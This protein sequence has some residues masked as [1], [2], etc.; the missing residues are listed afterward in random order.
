MSRDPISTRRRVAP[1][2]AFVGVL[3]TATALLGACTEGDDDTAPTSLATTTST[4]VTRDDDGQLVLGIFLPRTGAGAGLGQP[5]IAAID[6]A[7]AE[8][9]QVGGVL[10]RPV[11]RELV[12]E[13]SGTGMAELVQLGVDAII[14]P[15]SST[16]ALAQLD[17]AVQ[18][19]IGVV[20]C[21][22]SAT[23]LALDDYP[24]NKFFFRTV[25]SDSL[26]MT[27]I[28][29]LAAGTGV[30]S[31][32][33][34]YVDDVYGRGLAQAFADDAQNRTFTISAEVPF[35]ADQEELAATA[36]QLL[37][38]APGVVVVLGGPDDGTRLLAALDTATQGRERPEVIVNDAVRSGR[39]A[40]P[41]LSDEFREAIT[42]VAPLAKPVTGEA[43]G[44]F[45]ANAVDCVNLIALAAEQARS[46]S[47]RFI[48][49]QMAA[50]SVGGA[51]CVSFA[52]CLEKINDN[53]LIDYNGQTGSVELSTTTG[54]LVR[55]WF[56]AFA[57]DAEG[58]D[59]K[60][61]PGSPFQ[62]P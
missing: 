4:V 30:D 61:E 57:F 23:A 32:A 37:T 58:V 53:L 55:G 31:V 24:D 12:D 38:G 11:T 3:V 13:N 49:A 44:F 43:E 18:Q 6:A 14:G 50:A 21:S 56:E 17:D 19:D 42:G 5:M 48:Q 16:V 47:P 62:V 29:K 41:S 33:V 25:P 60:I 22:P 10:N 7:I 39:Q 15:A 26:Q 2:T 28:G 52:D 8:I 9:N 45:T 59:F 27:A 40:I 51:T 36:D 1:S 46:D 35:T 54:D 20:V 34:G